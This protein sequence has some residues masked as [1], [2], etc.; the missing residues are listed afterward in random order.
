[1]GE[2]TLLKGGDIISTSNLV[3][4]TID[5]LSFTSTTHGWLNIFSSAILFV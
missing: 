2:Q 4:E 3:H 1:M 5:G